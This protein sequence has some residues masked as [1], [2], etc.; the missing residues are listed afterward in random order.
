MR[1]SAF[2]RALSSFLACAM[3]ATGVPAGPV[4]AATPVHDRLQALARSITFDWARAHPLEATELGIY[5]EDGELDTPGRAENARDLA[6]IRHW[7]GELAAMPLGGAPLVDVDDAKLLRALLIRRER[8]YTTYK[9]YEKDYS[10]P[11][12]AIVGAVYTQFQHL[13]TAGTNGATQSDAIAAWDKIIA[14]LAHAPA[15]IAAGEALVDHPGH[16]YGVVGAQQLAGVEDFMNGALSAAAK[17]QLPPERFAAF[18]QARDATLVAISNAKKYIDAHVAGWPE[19]FAMGRPAYDAMLRDEE[20][21]PFAATDIERMAH[22]ELARGWAEQAWVVSDAAQRGTPIGQESGGGLAPSGAALIAYYRDRIAELRG[23]V[24]A[25][26]VVDVPDWLG[27]IDVVET[28]KFLQP[29]SPGASMDAPLLFAKD[30]RGFYY[31]TPP[32]SLE[33]AAERL[34]PN[35]DFDRDRILETAAHEAMPGHFLQ[36]SIA[37]RHPDFVRKTQSSGVF[38]EGWAFY[39]EEMFWQLGLY[40]DH[41][42]DARYDAA[43][44]ERVRGARAIVDPELASGAWSYERAVTFFADQTG[45]PLQ[46]AQAAV[47]GIALDPGYVISYTVGRF[48]LETLLG[49]YTLKTGSNGSLLDFHDRLLCYGT[50]PFAIVAP[51]LMADLDKPLAEVRAAANY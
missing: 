9:T 46:Q 21:L 30:P 16:L 15:Y 28:P 26:H 41:D 14:R 42:L 51:E 24:T 20:L 49:E 19:N 18:T 13:P 47:A 36:L 4:A 10:A 39:G 8:R 23:F 34:D 50:T 33:R 17:D 25:Q 40:G 45:F 43:Q 27:S 3:L 6:A 2:V 37:H 7:E 32:T 38:A 1:L 44:W 22:D 29:V 5:E 35:Q 31:I 12:Q 11:S 48:Q